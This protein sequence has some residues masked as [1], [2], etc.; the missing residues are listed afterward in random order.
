MVKADMRYL[1]SNGNRDDSV[2][3]LSTGSVAFHMCYHC[4]PANIN[5]MQS[6]SQS[7]AAAE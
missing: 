3:L 5:G 7:T 2:S 1:G 4:R 6:D